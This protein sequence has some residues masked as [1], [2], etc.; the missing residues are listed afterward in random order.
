MKQAFQPVF[1]PDEDTEVRDLGNFAF[2]HLTRL[3]ASR[4]IGRPRIVAQLLQAE[5]DSAS[6]GVDRKNLALQLLAFFQDFVRMADL[7]S[8]RHV[9]NVQQAI[10]AFFQ[11]DERTVV[12]KVANLSGDLFAGWVLLFDFVPR[13]LLSLLHAQRH[14]LARFVDAKN[15][16]IDL[17]AN[18][19][20]FAWMVNTLD[21]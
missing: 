14:L 1:Q 18:V 13:V 19:D 12:G 10:D 3:V 9:R 4:D 6:I 7:A 20:Q 21:P 15:A 8:P 2:D 16:D 5:C 11:F 17:I